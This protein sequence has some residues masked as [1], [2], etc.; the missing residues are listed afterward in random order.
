MIA[1]VEGVVAVRGIDE[2]VVMTAGGVGYRLSVSLQTLTDVPGVGERVRLLA[3]THVREDVLQLFGFREDAEREAFL[4]LT[5]ISGVGPRIALALLSGMA[6]PDLVRAVQQGDTRR[7]SAAPGI[8]KKTAERI[9]LELRDK[10][11]RL[12]SPSATLQR[13]MG[14]SPDAFDD[15][16]SAL[17]NLGYGA[18]VVERVAKQIEKEQPDGS[19]PPTLEELVRKALRLAR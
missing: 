16:R 3:H 6:V 8:G 13:A 15:L 12:G 18:A 17:L 10:V 11:A 7:L 4:L 9:V 14:T 1:I 2:V 19:P 5:S